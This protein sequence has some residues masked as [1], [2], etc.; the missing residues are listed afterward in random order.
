MFAKMC[1]GQRFVTGFG[2]FDAGG[3]VV[4][5]TSLAAL[6]G[7]VAGSWSGETQQ[8]E[9]QQKVFL[10]VLDVRGREIKILRPEKLRFR[11]SDIFQ[12]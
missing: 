4:A 5:R 11:F 8:H 2:R 7:V 10:H 12:V 3:L 6:L 1:D 9:Q